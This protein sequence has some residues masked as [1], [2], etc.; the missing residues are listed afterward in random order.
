MVGKLSANRKV[1]I[2]IY[3]NKMSKLFSQKVEDCPAMTEATGA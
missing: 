1:E 3:V 2:I